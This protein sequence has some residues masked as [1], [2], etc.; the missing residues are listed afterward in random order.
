MKKS[1][2]SLIALI[3]LLAGLL[4][5]NGSALLNNQIIAMSNFV[6]GCLTGLGLGLLVAALIIQIR[7]NVTIRTDNKD[8][9]KILKNEK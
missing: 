2:L 9:Q 8:D 3:L 7:T 4:L 1:K 6:R 5:A